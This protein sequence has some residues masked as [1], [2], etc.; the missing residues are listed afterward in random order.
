MGAPRAAIAHAL[1]SIGAGK[2]LQL[3]KM[4]GEWIR[5]RGA[6]GPRTRSM[7]F[8]AVAVACAAN[9]R[10]LALEHVRDAF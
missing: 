6:D 4:A 7:R 10:P 5:I 1:E 3:R 9:G 2:Q 8:D